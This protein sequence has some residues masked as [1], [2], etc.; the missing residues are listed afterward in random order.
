MSQDE[1]DMHNLF[2]NI[3]TIAVVGLSDR[4]DRASYGVAAFLAARGHRIIGV[5]PALVGQTM[6]SNPVVARLEDI[7]EPV[8]MVDVFRR[9]QDTPPIAQSA[10]AIGAKV[11]WLQLGIVNETA[12]EIAQAGGL[13]VVMDR[14][15]KI[16]LS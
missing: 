13:I 12:R 3:K 1:I 7:A 6:F 11:F 2:Q 10:V 14:C 4:P 9:G 5:N 16:E 15:P 8:D